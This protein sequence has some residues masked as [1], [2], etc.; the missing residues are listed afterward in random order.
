MPRALHV[1]QGLSAAGTFRQA[2]QSNSGELLVHDDVLSCG[3]LPP[4]ESFEQWTRVRQ[5][6]WDTVA[7]DKHV[8]GLYDGDHLVSAATFRDV[9]SIVVWMG[10]DLAEQLLL[11]WL[12][13]VLK[14]SQSRAQLSVVQFTHMGAHNQPVW[15]TGMLNPEQLK[16]H[17]PIE[18]LSAPKIAELER[19]WAA[20]TS[21]DPTA[22][23][24]FMC[25]DISPLPYFRPALQTLMRRYPERHTGIGRW[26]GALLENIRKWSPRILRVIGDT[27]ADNFDADLVGD[28][29]LFSR[30]RQLAFDRAH[31]L[32]SFSGDPASMRTCE[33]SLTPTGEAVLDGRANAIALNGI[34][35]WVLGVHLSSVHG[36]VWYY[37]NGTLVI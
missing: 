21:P 25:A 19:Y 33:V 11:A 4:F 31:P 35:E 23:L 15:G 10:I 1:V 36:T 24:A 34:D 29:Y 28:G 26:D 27:M 18:A 5:E 7:E 30:L 2:M 37:E 12:L 20:V 6:F 22:L 9:D 14:L 8:P 17:P 13:Q 32:V 16:S 3:P